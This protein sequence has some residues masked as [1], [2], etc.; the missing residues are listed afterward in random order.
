M[1][2]ELLL[3]ALLFYA[4]APVSS[5]LQVVQQSLILKETGHPLVPA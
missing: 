3:I 4:P 5:R 2:S 1:V